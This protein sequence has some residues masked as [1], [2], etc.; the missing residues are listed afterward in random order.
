MIIFI[1]HT[2]QQAKSKRNS[3]FSPFSFFLFFSLSFSLS[4][5]R[6]CRHPTALCRGHFRL[7][8]SQRQTR[9]PILM[10]SRHFNLFYFIVAII[11]SECLLLF[12]AAA[13]QRLRET[14]FFASEFSG[15]VVVRCRCRYCLRDKRDNQA[16]PFAH[17]F[18]ER[19][20]NSPACAAR[21]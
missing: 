19:L 14:T 9:P 11:M 4:L 7:F 18:P 10:R 13:T 3:F 21:R 5:L 8:L 6:T 17:R 12:S 2:I 1:K 20:E 15:R 16:L